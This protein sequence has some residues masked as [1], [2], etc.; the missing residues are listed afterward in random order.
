MNRCLPDLDISSLNV[1]IIED[2]KYMQLILTEILRAF[3]VRNIR[4]ATDGAEALDELKT[5]AADIV[6]CDWEMMPITGIEFTSMVRTMSDVANPY[7]SIILITGHT[8]A[9]KVRYARDQGVTEFLAK[10]VSAAMLYERI[11]SVIL[12]PRQFIKTKKYKGPDRRRGSKFISEARRRS[13]DEPLP[14]EDEQMS[15]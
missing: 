2:N 5:F 12:N 4:T 1:L 3:R 9:E 10:P 11:C 15:A 6:L 8:E 7:V 13:G 14:E